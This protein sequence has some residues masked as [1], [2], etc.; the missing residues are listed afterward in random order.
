[1][2]GN[3]PLYTCEQCAQIDR[4][5]IQAGLG[6]QQLMGQA[7]VALYQAMK[8]DRYLEP[9]PVIILCGRGNNGG[10][11]LALA[12]ILHGATPFNHNKISIFLTEPPVSPEALFYYRMLLQ[13]GQEIHDAHLFLEQPPAKATIVEALLG[14]GQNRA[15]DGL[16]LS[17]LMTL[18]AWQ[19]KGASLLSIDLPCGLL[20]SA[21]YPPSLPRPQHVYTIGVKKL[22][23][24]FLPDIPCAVLPIGFVRAEFEPAGLQMELPDPGPFFVREPLHHKYSA[25][26]AAGVGGSRGMRG[27]MLL[28]GRSFFAC[29]GGILFTRAM[30]SELLPLEPSF[31]ECDAKAILNKSFRAILIGPGLDP[32]DLER[33]R[34]SILELLRRHETSLRGVILDAAAIALIKDDAFP[35]SLREKTILTPH[36][37]EFARMIGP[38]PDCA[39]KALEATGIIAGLGVWCLCKGPTLCLMS[40]RGELHILPAALPAL[41]VAGSGDV[42]GGIL[43]AALSR[44]SSLHFAGRIRMALGL[45]HLLGRSGGHPLATELIDRIHRELAKVEILLQNS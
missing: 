28:A 34:E 12:W 16:L 40:P 44:D 7:A 36:Q 8:A 27:A 11:G 13:A 9:D 23:L 33:E 26:S 18:P 42:L 20:E 17:I 38:A 15:P 39:A 14:A 41:A 5:S 2:S 19:N 21:P 43:L 32:L 22:A 4:A 35:Q 30:D 45:Q 29:G 31:V 6:G 37:G 3:E 1:M 10:D 24:T 25:G